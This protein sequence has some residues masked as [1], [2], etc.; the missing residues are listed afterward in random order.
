MA[1]STAPKSKK[2][3]KVQE[4]V[5]EPEIE[6][7]VCEPEEEPEVEMVEPEVADDDKKGKKEKI[8]LEETKEECIALLKSTIDDLVA[9]LR[10]VKNYVVALENRNR[11]SMKETKK[12]KKN[13][14][15][16]VDEEGNPLP[17]AP[18][19]QVKYRLV[20]GVCKLFGVEKGTLM[21]KSEIH[22]RVCSYIKEHD[23][24]Q[25]VVSEKGV[26]KSTIEILPDKP[27]RKLF[28]EPLHRLLSKDETTDFGYSY[29]NL[30]IYEKN[31]YH[32]LEKKTVAETK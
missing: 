25:Y 6:E 1:R 31:L 15:E 20:D 2:T 11:K 21:Q 17:K 23:L 13:K 7:Q 30:F 27:L 16:E 9:K 4:V 22:K 12:A 5:K 3:V 32:A 19:K 18:R 28:G 24:K 8:Q 26:R 14:K 29:K 10:F